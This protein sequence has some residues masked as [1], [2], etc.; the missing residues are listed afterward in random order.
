M[1]PGETLK[2]LKLCGPSPCVDKAP[3][4]MGLIVSKMTLH[5]IQC[6]KQIQVISS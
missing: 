1:K 6:E 4:G 3:V 2:Q 5:K